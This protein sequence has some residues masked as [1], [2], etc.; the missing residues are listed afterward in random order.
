[1]T[2]EYPVRVTVLGPVQAWVGDDPVDLGA[3][4]QRA[5]L[6]RLVAARGDRKS[7]V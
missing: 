5:L 1:M 6:A 7:V 3:R 4:M 2:V